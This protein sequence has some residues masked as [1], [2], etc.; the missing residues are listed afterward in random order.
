MEVGTS[1]VPG[2]YSV[3]IILGQVEIRGF[4]WVFDRPLLPEW[5]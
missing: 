2:T 3:H 1:Q 4:A 5:M